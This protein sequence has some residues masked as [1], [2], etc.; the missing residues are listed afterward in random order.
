MLTLAKN[1]RRKSQV[2]LVLEGLD[3][4]FF[5]TAWNIVTNVVV[6]PV[7]AEKMKYTFKCE[8]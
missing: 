8:K 1:G 5:G 2:L 3:I 7:L 6:F 4:F